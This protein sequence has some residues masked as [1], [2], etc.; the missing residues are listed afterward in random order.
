MKT[1][2]FLVRRAAGS[3]LENLVSFA[4]AEAGEAEKTVRS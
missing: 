4:I 1:E 3:D 2:N